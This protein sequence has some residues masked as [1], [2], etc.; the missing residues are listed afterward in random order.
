MRTAILKELH[1]TL[2]TV[3]AIHSSETWDGMAE[4]TL[5]PFLNSEIDRVRGM[6]RGKRPRPALRV[7]GGTDMEGA[8]GNAA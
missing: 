5:I 8:N 3:Q 1:F 6:V 7:V 2:G 4:S